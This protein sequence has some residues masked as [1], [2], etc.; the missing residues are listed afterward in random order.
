MKRWRKPS[1]ALARIV[2]PRRNPL[3]TAQRASSG[4]LSSRGSYSV[5]IAASLPASRLTGACLPRLASVSVLVVAERVAAL[6]WL[7]IA[8]GLD[9]H[10]CAVIHAAL[11]PQESWDEPGSLQSVLYARYHLPRHSM[12]QSCD[13]ASGTE[14]SRHPPAFDRKNR[15][16]CVADFSNA[17]FG[18]GATNTVGAGIS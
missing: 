8:T 9:A 3:L 2:S 17:Y 14:T 11:A 18:N 10:D 1:I 15:R 12:S 5:A 13:A 4:S 7:R 16:T 6:D